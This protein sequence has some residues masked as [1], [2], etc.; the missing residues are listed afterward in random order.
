AA[1]AA[2]CEVLPAQRQ[3]RRELF[4]GESGPEPALRDGHVRRALN[5]RVE[6]LRLRLAWSEVLAYGRVRGVDRGVRHRPGCQPA[7]E[8]WDHNEGEAAPSAAFKHARA[9][10]AFISA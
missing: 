5:L 1:V 4:L 6:G 8:Q 10:P 2:L 9:L 7:A 3:P